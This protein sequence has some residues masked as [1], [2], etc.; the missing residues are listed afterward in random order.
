MKLKY[1]VALILLGSSFVLAYGGYLASF[2]YAVVA[3]LVALGLS[4]L[5]MLFSKSDDK[6]VVSILKAGVLFGA[7]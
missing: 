3:A 2:V 5:V 4:A 7:F 1:R 6:R